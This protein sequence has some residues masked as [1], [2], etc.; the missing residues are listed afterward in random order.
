MILCTEPLFK[1]SNTEG[2]ILFSN[3]SIVFKFD[4]FKQ[5]IGKNISNE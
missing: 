5:E 4:K 1:T 2:S 3:K